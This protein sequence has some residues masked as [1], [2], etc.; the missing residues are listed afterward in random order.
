MSIA[1]TLNSKAATWTAWGIVAVLF[2]AALL[3]ANGSTIA[4]FTGAARTAAI[5]NAL[6]DAPG[7]L[8][9]TGSAPLFW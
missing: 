5:E 8:W 2:V 9:A 4:A 1:R 7:G 6:A 3:Y